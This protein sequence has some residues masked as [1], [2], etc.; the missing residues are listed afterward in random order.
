MQI[1]L[2][3]PG[4]S[5]ERRSPF[6][7]RI[8]P[9]GLIYI[10]SYLNLKGFTVG[11][12]DAEAENLQNE[13]ICEIVKRKN[14]KIVGITLNCSQ[15]S[16]GEPLARLL[17]ARLPD[18]HICVG[19]PHP[20]ALEDKMLLQCNAIDSVVIGEGEETFLE[21]A[22]AIRDSS[23]LQDVLGIAFR[24]PEGKIIKTSPRPL[25]PNLDRLPYP[26]YSLIPDIRNYPGSYPMG[27]HPSFPL[28]ASRGCPFR[29]TFCSDSV[30][31][32]RVRRRT[33]ENI[34]GELMQLDSNY[35]VREVF[36]LDDAL[37][38]KKDWFIEICRLIKEKGL[39][40]KII[41]K[42][43]MRAN[44]KLLT[45]EILQAAQE[46]GFWQL[47]FGI[48]SGDQ[49]ILNTIN[50]SL[51]V[52]EA[53][54]A[55]R[56]TRK[57]GI[58]T[59]ATFMIGNLDES[60]KSIRKTYR[61][62][63]RIDPDYHGLSTAVPF[64]ETAFYRRAK[65]R[66]LLKNENFEDYH[67]GVAVANTGYLSTDEVDRLSLKYRK[68]MSS[69]KTS[70]RRLLK[71]LLNGRN[72]ND[73]RAR[74]WE[75]TNAGEYVEKGLICTYPM[76]LNTK[77][78]KYSVDFEEENREGFHILR[79]GWYGLENGEFGPSRWSKKRASVIL[80]YDENFDLLKFRM[81]IS[82]ADASASPVELSIR[83]CGGGSRR[84]RIDHNRWETYGMQIPR[85][86][87]ADRIFIRLKFNRTFNPQKA[88]NAADSRDLGGLFK[89][90]WLE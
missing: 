25:I 79:D 26:D 81:K 82:H 48:E 2:I 65:E 67:F 84:F 19:G 57:S 41:L 62:F 1:T 35:H 45:D 74:F 42:G 76:N 38:L 75:F 6:R 63:K 54:R 5:S 86:E 59:L 17:R 31:H 70:L 3:H 8:P 50:K 11:V 9:L 66:G 18:V 12:L 44:T 83:T 32:G 73:L 10:A 52:E 71:T 7:P 88:H 80:Q 68:K 56:L 55:F 15:L 87:N 43:Q 34:V 69:Y 78:L 58:K 47:F 89:R 61:L 46:S 33:A 22:S 23:P 14:S 77:F 40:E 64:P 29:C 85:L 72:L 28:L 16:T 36:F 60:K 4:V 37:N 24:S 53:I 13:E 27:A 39:S 21:L 20:S 51:S 90:V 30:W 49:H